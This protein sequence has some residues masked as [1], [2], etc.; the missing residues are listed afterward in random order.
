MN[1]DE[2]FVLLNLSFLLS[3]MTT[4][5]CGYDGVVYECIDSQN[6]GQPDKRRE[7]LNNK[8]GYG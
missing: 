3:K 5:F 7:Y 1:D 2:R 8:I 4:I 6:L